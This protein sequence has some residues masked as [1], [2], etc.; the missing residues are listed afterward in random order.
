MYKMD[1]AR[2]MHDNYN[3]NPRNFEEKMDIEEPYENKKQNI[4]ASFG[5][6]TE[7]YKN[8]A[9]LFGANDR[10]VGSASYKDAIK[11]RN[12]VNEPIPIRGRE[13]IP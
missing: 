13:I 4:P 1:Q 8:E 12:M 9:K 7:N 6:K 10:R 11:G 5:R 3:N 2:A